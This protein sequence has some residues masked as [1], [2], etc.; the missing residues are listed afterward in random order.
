MHDRTQQPDNQIS[1]GTNYTIQ[2]NNFMTKLKAHLS[3]TG[4]APQDGKAHFILR[5]SFMLHLYL[6]ARVYSF[7][8]L[9]HVEPIEDGRPDNDCEQHDEGFGRLL[10]Q[11]VKGSVGDGLHATVD[12]GK[13][14]EAARPLQEE[15][16]RANDCG[17]P[18]VKPPAWG[19]Q[20]TR[21]P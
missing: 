6:F 1:Y 3:Y 19:Q 14:P 12:H 4:T 9:P 2:E 18:K 16:S 10:G 17:R 15:V 5:F 7:Q 20:K 21:S 13:R 8:V 11:L